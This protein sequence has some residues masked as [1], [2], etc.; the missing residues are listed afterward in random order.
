M[1]ILSM[2]LIS[3]AFAPDSIFG[4]DSMERLTEFKPGS[5][6][7]GIG[8]MRQRVSELGGKLKLENTNPGTLVQ[9]VIPNT[10]AEKGEQLA[11]PRQGTGWEAPLPSRSTLRG[12]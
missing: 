2:S 12:A 6:G 10:S 4:R 5:V 8:G 1:F 11:S 9:V 7:V 3:K